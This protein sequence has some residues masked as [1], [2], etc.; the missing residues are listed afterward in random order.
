MGKSPEMAIHMTR[1]A[2]PP[3]TPFAL[4]WNCSSWGSSACLWKY[5]GV[6][7]RVV[8]GQ[9]HKY[10]HTHRCT[11]ISAHWFVKGMIIC[12]GLK[13][14]LWDTQVFLENWYSLRVCNIFSKYLYLFSTGF[15]INFK[16][17]RYRRTPKGEK[18]MS[19]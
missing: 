5:Q 19:K 11:T 14:I 16:C 9:K 6:E 8:H 17:F 15:I 12:G 18:L 3:F 7:N 4:K 13:K 2:W 1:T 10:I